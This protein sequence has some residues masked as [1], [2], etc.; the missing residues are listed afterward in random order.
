MGGFM[1]N[2]CGAADSYYKLKDLPHLNCAGCKNKTLALMELRRK[3]R[4]LYIPTV[5]LNTKYAV[6]CPSCKNGY[7]VNEEQKNYILNNP[8]ECVEMTS[9]GVVIHRNPARQNPVQNESKPK[10]TDTFA[11]DT[12]GS[13]K[14]SQTEQGS[15]GTRCVC[16]YSL[17][18]GDAFCPYCGTKAYKETENRRTV[19]IPD[20]DVINQEKLVK[21]ETEIRSYDETSRQN[22]VANGSSTF[23]IPNVRRRKVCPSCRMMF[24]PEKEVCT[25]C[26]SQLVDKR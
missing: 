26:G 3:V 18:P 22:A 14:E 4:V 17:Q 1:I 8:A 12:L 13:G 25:I 16:G 21:V 2:G 23:A 5:T 11:E 6:V 15:N 7:Y 9:D 24:A 20:T 19:E 10:S